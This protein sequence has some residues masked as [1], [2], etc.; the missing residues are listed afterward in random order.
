MFNV[1]VTEKVKAYYIDLVKGKRKGAVEALFSFFL[2]LISFIYGF[3]IKLILLSYQIKLF[4]S[5][6]PDCRVVS[7][8]NITWGGTG[9]T[10]LVETLVKFFKQE[11]RNPVVLI[12]GYGK[13][14]ALML[15]DKLKNIPVLA[16]SNRIKNVKVAQ[17]AYAADVIILD[18]G[19]QHWRL[20]RDLDIVLID[21]NLPFGNGRLIPRGILR[22]PLSSLSRADIFVLTK[23]NLAGEEIESIKRE[24]RK[25]NSLAPIYEAIHAP[26][27]LRSLISDKKFELSIIKDRRI[28]LVS[29]IADSKSFAQ[30][31]SSL[32]SE[33]CL[34]FNFSDHYQYRREDLARIEK[35]SLAEQIKTIVTTEKDA[36]KLRPLLNAQRLK[37]EVLVLGIEVRIVKDE[38]KFFNFLKNSRDPEKPYSVLILSDGKAGHLNQSKAIAGIIQRRKRD[39]GFG[40]NSLKIKIVEV[41]FK[42]RILQSLLSCC[43]IFSGPNCRSCLSCLR[44]CLEK[45]SFSELIQSPAD[46]IISAGSSLSAVNLFL[47]YRNK[48]RAIILMK[49]SLLNVNRFD[50][51]IVPE[52]DGIATGEN[53]VTT[54]MAPNLIN[55]KYLEDQANI[56]KTRYKIQDT[57]YSSK[58]PTIGVLIGGDAA[59]YR[60]SAELI[61]RVVSQL[62]EVSQDL[63]CQL[64]VTTSRRTPK[65][66]EELL[67]QR[68]AN[69]PGCK[70]L[71]IANE[72]NIP[73][74]VGGILGL[75][76]VIVVSGESIS[77]VSEAISARKYVLAF[78]P[79]KKPGRVTKQERFLEKLETEELLKVIRPE[80]LAAQI[81]ELWK[82]KP[83]I[84]QL[85]DNKL[86]YQ[87]ISTI[88]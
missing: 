58:G 7:V 1:G 72:T 85:Q 79:E 38:A 56:L 78:I 53:I 21:S 44:F 6:K 88:V 9:K 70:L 64:L 68:L 8:G 5:Y 81:K 41:K 52:H 74:T 60:L 24:L 75:S 87:A 57:R 40:E 76:D 42:N 22:E 31:I 65:E 13:D 32:G 37:V 66:V 18:D 36:A 17:K 35:A 15:K 69:F 61:N 12:R 80:N 25:Y 29:G 33:I 86:I 83:S 27:F 2:L 71:V 59:K 49:P 19:F 84:R 48:A 82:E 26:C 50:L 51:V 45:S 16:G 4:K 62:K 30:I 54:T 20:G 73:E 23:A 43:A 39:Q 14:E 11:G 46:V 77:M 28:A 34:N 47:S 3:F 63:N 10:P 67:K 55:Q